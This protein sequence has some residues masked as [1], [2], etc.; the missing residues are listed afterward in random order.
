MK[1]TKT[2]NPQKTDLEKLQKKLT[3]GFAKDK[4]SLFWVKELA[5]LWKLTNGVILDANLLHEY[6]ELV[7]KSLQEC[8]G[9]DA[10]AE[11]LP[12]GKVKC[13]HKDGRLIIL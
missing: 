11:C 1:I 5:N 3:D 8:W 10:W 6:N 9:Q 12:D 7:N 4:M 2:Q 13:H